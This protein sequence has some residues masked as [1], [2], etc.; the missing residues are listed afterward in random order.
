MYYGTKGDNVRATK[1]FQKAF[2]LDARE[3]QAAKILAENFA[4][5][6]EWELLAV[7][8]ERLIKGEG[9]QVG[10]GISIIQNSW[11]WKAL[12]IVDMVSS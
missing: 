11:A 9:S 3:I 10:Q 8:A 7:V 12:G 5:E 6:E 1:C 4:Q 2:E